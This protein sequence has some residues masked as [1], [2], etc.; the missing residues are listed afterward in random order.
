MYYNTNSKL[1]RPDW[2]WLLC[3]LF[4]NHIFKFLYSA[5]GTF[6][7]LINQENLNGKKLAPQFLLTN[8]TVHWLVGLCV[9]DF[10]ILT[11]Y[12]QFCG[13]FLHGF[14]VLWHLS[15]LAN[16]HCLIAN[17]NHVSFIKMH[18]VTIQNTHVS[19]I[20]NSRWKSFYD[21]LL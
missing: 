20:S 3:T 5:G 14:L 7:L 12:M 18:A 10:P 6:V 21:I 9:S 16:L 15:N 8:R 1:K 13:F 19:W 4:V 2:F 17:C 11:T